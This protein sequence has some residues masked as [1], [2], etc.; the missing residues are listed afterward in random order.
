M[1]TSILNVRVQVHSQRIAHTQ[2]MYFQ[3]THAYAYNT[4]ILNV[5][6]HFHS[7]GI[8]HIQYIYS[9]RICTHSFILNVCV[10][11]QHTFSTYVY[12]YI[13]PCMRKYVNTQIDGLVY[14]WMNV[15][16]DTLTFCLACVH[17]R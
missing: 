7:Q 4:Y 3:R 13:L 2:H 12:T 5:R 15:W 16:M 1:H 10:R 14:V 8:V 9:Q 11:I 6:V 17:V